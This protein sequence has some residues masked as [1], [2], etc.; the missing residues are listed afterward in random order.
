MK[1]V[2][3]YLMILNVSIVAQ[4]S[5]LEIMPS[6]INFMNQFEKNKTVRISNHGTDEII[7][8]S[9]KYDL[10]MLYVRKNDFK[11]FPLTLAPASS[12]S[13]DVILTN[14]FVMHETDSPSDIKIFNSSN[15]PI[16]S[17]KVSVNFEMGNRMNGVIKGSVKDTSNYLAD[18]KL[19]F[20]YDGIYLIDSTT[21]DINGTFEKELHVGNYFV[22]ALKGGY[23]M[24]YSNFKYSPLDANFIE[25]RKN[26]PEI[27]DFILEAEPETDL[28]ISGLVYD[29][30]TKE[31][32]NRAIVVVRKGD[33]T[34][35]KIQA[36][37]ENPFHDY[38]I[39]TNSK[40]EFSINNIQISG[41]YY[42][43]AFSQYYIPGYYNHMNE[44]EAFWQEADSID[45]VGS[46]M[47][48]NVYLDRDS[49]YGGGVARGHVRLNNTQSDSA[50]NTLVFAVSTLNNK[51]YNY[52]F[53]KSSGKFD[54]PSLPSGG[55]KLVAN[56]IG[57]N[58]SE[59]DEFI[60]NETQDTVSNI[61]L[62][63]LPTSVKQTTQNIE[64]FKLG[65][66]YPNPFNPSTTIEFSLEKYDYVTL[67]IYN[68]LGQKIA[69]L[70]KGN[71]S[72]GTY[73]LT[74]DASHLSSGIYLYQLKSS[75]STIVK[76][77]Q[78][79]K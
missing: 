42:L 76:K 41:N 44:H 28:S 43:E 38:A 36:S 77:M 75:T 30:V 25:V 2:L 9:I 11:S 69:E 29:Q 66:N 3:I 15:E 58:N 4:M 50:N 12:I 51:V 26:T 39:V 72:S 65:Q 56:K 16:K 8:D 7:I 10:S 64:A 48:K 13:I 35:S 40:G 34:P 21:T 37:F 45:V 67:T 20:F 5:N 6:H 52:N 31:A 54:L 32:I 79:M 14:Y 53:S 1:R 47:G 18:V 33:H 57:Y 23:Y 68:L 78:L 22:A 62:V 55:Y 27:V 71:Y 74:F 24:Q 70:L 60:I 59:S 46:E 61:N 63:L 73:K 19:F 17:A 49:S